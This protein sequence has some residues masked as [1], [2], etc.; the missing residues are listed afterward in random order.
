MRARTPHTL[1][2]TVGNGRPGSVIWFDTETR[3]HKLKNGDVR[4]TLRL[5]VAEHWRRF[6]RRGYVKQS[7]L[8]FDD[9]D[10]F[11]SWL[12]RCCRNKTTTYL[13]SHNIV[14]DIAIVHA[15]VELARS[16]WKLQS[17]YSKA[18]TSIFRWKMGE[19]RLVAIDNMNLFQG[20]LEKWG[21]LF[22]YPKGHV[23][24]D[25]VGDAELL[26]YCHRDV[27]IMVRSWMEWIK[28]LD[29]H[30]LGNFKVTIG[31]TALSAW[32]HRFMTA[33]VWIH[34]DAKALGL[35]RESY[36]GGRT[37]CFW[38]GSRNDGPFY[39]LDV[40]NM[41]GY[42]M[43]R[44]PYPAGI[45]QTVDDPE[46]GRLLRKLDK[47]AVIARV[48]ICV[49]EPVFPMGN[50]QHFY[51]PVGEF[52]TTLTTPELILAITKGWFREVYSMA[53]Y[54]QNFL[55]S[56]Y[57]NYFHGLRQ[58]YEAAGN[59]GY[60]QISKMLNN[61]LYGK[62]GQLGYDQK[63]V[64]DAKPEET[65][66]QLV[67]D[68]KTHEVYRMFALGG[69]VYEERKAGEAANSFP[70]IAAHATAYARLYLWHLIRSAGRHHA[71]YCDTDSIIVDQ[72]GYDNLSYLLDPHRLG[73]LK[74]EH[75]SKGLTINAPKDYKMDERIRIKGVT[76]SADYLDDHTVIQE[77]WQRLGG[78]I[79][80][81]STNDYLVGHIKKSLQRTIHSGEVSPSGWI[82]P[83]L[84]G[85]G[86]SQSAPVHS[87]PVDGY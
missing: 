39:Y 41:Y 2:P 22:G 15:F 63:R 65:W 8:E 84:L 3:A 44:Y 34:N 10:T 57:I 13:V 59:T 86:E 55:F 45:W 29:T 69:G 60:A 52:V 7:E 66:S 76:R 30:E 64:G 85:Q 19:R 37:E 36:H 54:R 53:W 68:A 11:W 47:Q 33:R 32:R 17:F 28:F 81:G 35:E 40:N 9:I 74:V 21:D 26:T 78:Q 25:T 42:V 77:K 50:G 49:D 14:F 87:I 62:F 73:Y 70:A 23:D 75:V 58:E 67:I 51:Y 16:G 18:T 20:K 46:P 24:F 48:K 27:E 79:Q 31:S 4:H 1:K 12:D 83:Y 5:G 71:F 61:S 43:A 6:K 80:A 56:D 72:A 38:V 82:Q